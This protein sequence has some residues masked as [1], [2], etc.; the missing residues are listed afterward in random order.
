MKPGGEI[1]EQLEGKTDGKIERHEEFPGCQVLR[2]GGQR[3]QPPGEER[4][5]TRLYASVHNAA[6]LEACIQEGRKNLSFPFLS[7]RHDG[8]FSA[9]GRKRTDRFEWFLS[10]PVIL[11]KR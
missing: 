9:E 7:I 11:R 6:L 10:L 8:R 1:L 2:E 3:I 5:Q 4:K